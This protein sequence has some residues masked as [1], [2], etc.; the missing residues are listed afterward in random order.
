MVGVGHL[1]YGFGVS[2]GYYG[3]GLYAREVIKPSVEG[4]FGLSK[5]QIGDVFGIFSLVM[6]GMALI[7]GYTIA[8]LGLHVVVSVGALVAT[9][10]FFC[11]AVRSR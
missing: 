2:P 8:H 3:W 1:C 11:S 7:A 9:T 4:G 6:S 10:G 5:E